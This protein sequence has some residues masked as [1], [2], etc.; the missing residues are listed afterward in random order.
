MVTDHRTDHSVSD[1]QGV[2]NGDIQPFI[3]AMLKSPHRRR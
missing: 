3:D 2:L 1:A